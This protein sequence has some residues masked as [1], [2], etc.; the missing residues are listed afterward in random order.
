MGPELPHSGRHNRR[1]AVN[2]SR[3][4]IDR[5]RWISYSSCH[6][7]RRAVAA[8]LD[9]RNRTAWSRSPASRMVIVM[10]DAGVAMAVPQ[11]QTW[12]ERL[13]SHTSAGSSRRYAKRP[14]R[15]RKAS[16]AGENREPDHCDTATLRHCDK[17]TWH[18]EA[19]SAGFAHI[20]PR[21]SFAMPFLAPSFARLPP[22]TYLLADQRN[23]A[24]RSPATWA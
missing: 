21:W 17:L 3:T 4:A 14:P 19:G 7:P 20:A 12:V 9:R 18:C 24:R 6:Q 22:L 1:E 15:G 5:V 11:A 10:V 23:R 16:R 13:C 8:W 2:G